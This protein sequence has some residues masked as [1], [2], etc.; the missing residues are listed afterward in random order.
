MEEEI[1]IIHLDEYRK[2]NIGVLCLPG[3]ET[4]LPDI[5]TALQEKYVMKT[6]YGM[7]VEEIEKMVN[8][9]DILWLEW[10]NN[11]CVEVTNKFPILSQK[12]VI[13]RC[14]SYEALSGFLPQ[15][16]WEMVNVLIFVADH[17]KKLA[18]SQVPQLQ[19]GMVDNN[20]ENP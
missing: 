16:R 7:D 20:L 13:V 1:K 15:I 12:K 9:S 11:L 17:I 4:F 3:L 2:K 6:Y 8:W 19:Q 10:A 5:I 14:H 18:V